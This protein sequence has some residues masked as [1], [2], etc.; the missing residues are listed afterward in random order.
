VVKKE[1][2]FILQKYAF[3]KDDDNNIYLIDIDTQ[4]SVSGA[5]IAVM[6]D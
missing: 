3:K 5:A 1:D 2:E 4:E 6:S